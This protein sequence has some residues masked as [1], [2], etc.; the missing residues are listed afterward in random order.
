MIHYRGYAIEYD[1]PPI[2]VR[3]CDWRFAADGFDG[4]PD[5][6]DARSGSAET[7]EDAKEQIDTLIDEEE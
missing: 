6:K 7:L 5:S 1:P 2:P 3:C 4:A